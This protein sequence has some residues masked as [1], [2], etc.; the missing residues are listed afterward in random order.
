MK[1]NQ[2]RNAGMRDSTTGYNTFTF[3]KCSTL[4]PQE[5]VK[6]NG[7]NVIPVTQVSRQIE[8]AQLRMTTNYDES[9]ENKTLA[10]FGRLQC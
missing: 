1:R 5:N 4:A 6:Q 2:R 7:S 3:F 8:R 10:I 9:L